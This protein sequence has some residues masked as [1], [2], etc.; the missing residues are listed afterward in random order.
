MSR[1]IDFKGYL[2]APNLKRVG[3]KVALK[4]SEVEQFIKCSEDP[5]YFIE[6][7]VKIITVDKGFVNVSLYD[8]QKRAV[9]LIHDN[10]RVIIKAGRQVGKTTLVV[11]YILWYVLFN[12]D[13]TVAILA[14]KAK[15]SREILNRIKLAYESLP[16]WIQQGV[17]T[18][19][20]GD[21]ELENNC[22]ILAES[23]ASS[24]VRGYSINC[25]TEETKICIL[26]EKNEGIYHAEISKLLNKSEFVEVDSKMYYT[27]YKTTNK[28]NGKIYIGYHKTADLEDGY[29]GS[30]RLIKAA[31]EKYGV[32]SFTKEILAIFDTKKEAEDYEATLVNKD[33]TLREDTY[34]L[35]LG[36]NVR[37]FHGVNN[38]FF[39]RKHTEETKNHLSEIRKGKF[40]Y[41]T[42]FIMGDMF[43]KSMSDAK[44]YF[45]KS[46]HQL[47][48]MAGDPN[49]DLRF[50]DQTKQ[51]IAEEKYSQLLTLTDRQA[52]HA[53]KRFSGVKKS[54]EHKQKI[55]N[56]LRGKKKTKE[57]IDKINLNPEK[58]KKTA[59]K[60]RGMKRSLETRKKMGLAKKGKSPKNKGKVYCYNPL[61]KETKVCFLIDIPEGWNRGFLP[62]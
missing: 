8:F 38:G 26:N 57:H 37:V 32:N 20:K 51:K 39:G 35:T 10:R 49:C 2:G 43:F 33:F 46:R 56:A 36:G 14:N 41:G 58:I 27:V 24:A 47:I 62:K 23:T 1:L 7:F 59:D 61:T 21:I 30:G 42:E 54:D 60:H 29:L 50:I 48:N 55:S 15:T 18:W 6:N 53:K 44:E 16:L 52:S 17:K 28:V 34:N 4:E 12:E 3:I 22:R 40:T 45:N 5:T 13:K 31:V 19:N 25:V 9:N 11:G